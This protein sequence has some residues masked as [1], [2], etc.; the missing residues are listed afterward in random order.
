MLIENVTSGIRSEFGNITVVGTG[1]DGTPGTQAYDDGAQ[2]GIFIVTGGS[3]RST[4]AGTD[5]ADI[6]LRGFGGGGDGGANG[7]SIFQAGSSVTT[8]DGDISIFGVAA[9][10]DTGG[11]IGISVHSNAV[12]ATTGTGNILLDG[13]HSDPA[14][15]VGSDNNGVKIESGA[16]IGSSLSSAGAGSITI[17]GSAGDG[18]SGSHGVMVDGA[19]TRVTTVAGDISLTG[20]A[21]RGT[22]SNSAGVHVVNSGLVRTTGTGSIA[23]NGSVADGSGSLSGNEFQGVFLLNGATVES[24]STAAGSGTISIVGEGGDGV[25]NNHGIRIQ[26]STVNSNSGAIDLEGTG[27]K[28]SGTWNRGL[29][30]WQGA[31]VSA[32]NEASLSIDGTAGSGTDN[33]EGIQVNGSTVSVHDGDLLLNGQGSVTSTGQGNR[34]ILVTQ[35][36][37][38]T[39]SGTGNITINAAGGTGTTFNSG[40]RI[41]SNGTIVRVNDGDLTIVGTGNGSAAGDRNRG[42]VIGNDT[43]LTAVGSGSIFLTGTGG[44]GTFANFGITSFNTPEI[45]TISGDIVL[46]GIAGTSSNGIQLTSSAANPIVAGGA[47]NVTII[48]STTL[49]VTGTIDAATGNVLLQ[50][51]GELSL[52]NT[53]TATRIEVDSAGNSLAIGGTAAT[54]TGVNLTNTKLAN[55]NAVTLTVGRDATVVDTGDI[56]LNNVGELTFAPGASLDV[57]LPDTAAA[58]DPF[59]VVTDGKQVNLNNVG[60][61][62][63][64]N[65]TVVG[66]SRTIFE[67]A[68]AAGISV[69][70]MAGLPEGAQFI[71]GGLVF[72]VTYTGGIGGNDVV[73]TATGTAPVSTN[74]RIDVRNNDLFIEDLLL[75]GNDDSIS[76][77]AFDNAGIASYLI[78]ETTGVQLDLTS[79]AIAAGASYH[80]DGSGPILSQVVIPVSAFSGNINA[81]LGS[82]TDTV[83]IDF[84]GGAFAADI[85][86]NAGGQ[87]TGPGDSLILLGNSL[88]F[89]SETVTHT[90]QT[91]IGFDGNIELNDGTTISTITFT[92]LEPLTLA[93]AEEIVVN[94]PDG[95]DNNDVVIRSGLTANSVDILGSTFE[96]TFIPLVTG[97]LI[98]NGGN[99][100]DT[101]TVE[102][103]DLTVDLTV[104]GGIGVDSISLTDPV[105]SSGGDLTLIADTI[106]VATS[107]DATGGDGS[108][109]VTLTA[110]RNIVLNSGSSITVADGNAT[111]TA[112]ANGVQSGSFVGVDISAAIIESTGAGEINIE[113]RGGDEAGTDNHIGVLIRNGAAI[114]SSAASYQGQRINIVGEGGFGRSE[115]YGVRIEDPGTLIT[116]GYGSIT[117][118][119]TGRGTDWNNMGVLITENAVIAST[120]SG[121]GGPLD[122]PASINITGTGEGTNGGGAIGVK[123]GRNAGDGSLISTIDGDITIIGTAGEG[124]DNDAVNDQWQ[125][126]V[127]ILNG[128][129]VRSLGTGP[130]A[131]NITIIGTGGN[132]RAFSDGI[133]IQGV[134]SEVTA[135]DGNITLTGEA[136]RGV[137]NTAHGIH[138]TSNA[139]VEATGT[140][141]IT[142]TGTVK[143]DDPGTTADD[144]IHIGTTGMT[145]ELGSMVKSANGDVELTGSGR[146]YGVRL[147]GIDTRVESGSGAITI[148]ANPVTDL[149]HYFAAVSIESGVRVETTGI[150]GDPVAGGIILSGTV[151]RSVFSATAVDIN[152]GT[153]VTEFG[154]ILIS[155]GQTIDAANPN[156]L[157]LGVNIAG[158]VT[159]NGGGI[160]IEAGM[161]PGT[162]VGAGVEFN[163]AAISATSGDITVTAVA[164]SDSAI[165]L[166]GSTVLQTSNGGSVALN[167]VTA[168]TDSG[169]VGVGVFGGASIASNGTLEISG[170][171]DAVDGI[172]TI[173]TEVNSDGSDSGNAAFVTSNGLLMIS[174]SQDLV[175]R[176]G[177]ESGGGQ[178]QLTA[179]RHIRLQQAQN[180]I[181]TTGGDLTIRADNDGTGSGVYEQAT[182]ISTEGGDVTVIAADVVLTGIIDAAAGSITFQHSVDDSLI[183]LG[184]SGGFPAEAVVTDVDSYRFTV[185]DGLNW[186]F[187]GL[188]V[189]SAGD[190]NGDGIDDLLIAAPFRQVPDSNSGTFSNAGRVFVVFGGEANLR[191]L[192]TFDGTGFTG[193]EDRVISLEHLNPVGAEGSFP[194]GFEITGNTQ[195]GQ[196]GLSATAVGDMNGDGMDDLLIGAPGGF[197]SSGPSGDAF[198]VFGHQSG[199]INLSA[200]PANVLRL[201]G[202]NGGDRFGSRVA[203]GDVNG[204]GNSDLVIVNDRD[205]NRAYVVFGAAGDIA[206]SR[207]ALDSIDG[208]AD[209]VLDIGSLDETTGMIIS[210]SNNI[211]SVAVGDI[212]GDGTDDLILGSFGYDSSSPVGFTYVLFGED[213]ADLDAALGPADGQIDAND[214]YSLR[215]QGPSNENASPEV[216]VIGDLNGDGFRDL[217]IGA[218]Y[219]AGV[220][221]TGFNSRV[222]VVFGGAANLRALDTFGEAVGAT[223]D[224]KIQLSNLNGSNGFF[225]GDIDAFGA[226]GGKL[227][228]NSAGDING[229]GFDDLLIGAPT[230]GENY[231]TRTGAVHVVFGQDTDTDNDGAVDQPFA[232]A[233]SANSLGSRG[234][235]LTGPDPFER[236]GYAVT[237]AGDINGD[238]I[239]DLAA[240]APFNSYFGY[241]PESPGSVYVVFG[242]SGTPG[243]VAG[244]FHLSDTELA[245]LGATNVIIDAPGADSITRVIDD[246]YLPS[247]SGLIFNGGGIVEICGDITVDGI[248]PLGGSTGSGSGTTFNQD[249]VL[250]ENVTLSDL[251]SGVFFN[252]SVTFGTYDPDDPVTAEIETIR[253]L[254]LDVT[255][256][257]QPDPVIVIGDDAS[258]ILTLR[259]AGTDAD[260]LHEQIIVAGKLELATSLQLAVDTSFSTSVGMEI[261]LIE[262]DG[263]EAVTGAFA[264]VNGGS[265]AEG[266]T[267]ILNGENYVLSY[268][269]GDGNDV[270]L[271][272]AIGNTAPIAD[273]GGPYVVNEGS[274]VTLNASG[275]SDA[276]DADSNLTFEWD[277]DG[278]GQFDDAIGITTTFTALDG[279]AIQSV[280][281]RVTD[282]GGL[283]STTSAD[284]T[285]NNVAPTV[286]A[287]NAFVTAEEGT[288]ATN[289]G[290]FDDVGDDV[291]TITA[292]IGSVTQG[293]GTWNWSYDT[294]DGPDNSGPVT[295][296][297]TDSDG[298]TATVAFD[299]T[300]TNVTPLFD[301]GVNETVA[302]TAAGAF[303]RTVSF[304]D[305]G[306]LDAHTISIDYDGDGTTDET[307]NPA[308][309]A[310]SFNLSHTFAASGVYTV[311]ITVAD[312]DGASLTD[313]FVVTVNAPTIEFTAATYAI[314]EAAGNSMQVTLTRTGDS[315]TESVVRVSL[316]GGTATATGSAADFDAASFPLDVV[317]AAGESSKTV[318]LPI[319]DDDVGELSETILLSVI[320]VSNASIGAVNS[321]EVTIL[322]NDTATFTINDVTVT[323][324]GSTTFTISLDQQIDRAVDVTVNLSGDRTDATIASPTVTFAAGE[325]SKTVTIAAT[326]DNIVEASETLT[327]SLTV[328]RAEGYSTDV[329][330]TAEVTVIDND[331]ATFTINDVTVTE[332]GSTVL[333]ILLDH[334]IDTAVDVTVNLSGDGS[335]ASI[336]SPTVTF[337]AG[338]TSKT[339]IIAA[340]DDNIVEASETLTASLTVFG[341]EGYS[342]DVSDTAEVTI[343]DN[344]TAT[345]TI[346]DVTVTE[347]G[348]RTFTIS[349]DQ[350]I[351]RAVD[352]AVNL[353]GNGTDATIASPTVT[354]AAGETSKTVTIT[355]TDD[356][357]VEASE[358]L[359][360]SL[361]VF[362][363]EGYSVDATDTGAVTIV[364]NDTATFTIDD[365]IVSEDVGTATFIISLNN[366]LDV[367][368]TIELVLPA[369]GDYSIVNSSVVF[370]AGSATPQAV[371]V[372][373]T[374][375]DL[376]EATEHFT[377]SLS[378]FGAE[379]YSVDVTDT[380]TLTIIDNDAGSGTATLTID[381]VTALEGDQ[382][383]TEFTFTV[384]L[385][386]VVDTTVTV[387]VETGFFTSTDITEVA[388]AE[389]FTARSETL[390]FAP[391]DTA[392]TFTVQV[393]GD[394]RI[395]QN[396]RFV[397]NLSNVQSG[398]RDVQIGDGQGIGTI[399]MDD[400]AVV[401]I[402]ALT[403]AIVEGDVALFGIELLNED[404]SGPAEFGVG[405]SAHFDVDASTNSLGSTADVSDIDIAIQA[406]VESRSD[407]TIGSIIYTAPT[408]G[409]VMSPAVLSL[410]TLDDLLIER[411]ETLTVSV[412]GLTTADGIPTTGSTTAGSVDVAIADNDGPAVWMLTQMNGAD[413]ST[414]EGD[415]AVFELSL[416]GTFGSDETATVELDISPESLKEL[417]I[418]PGQ[419]VA[420]VDAVRAAA[421]IDPDVT[422]TGTGP[423]TIHFAAEADG[424]S[425]RTLSIRLP[426]AVD[427]YIEGPEVLETTLQNP[428]GSTFLAPVIFGGEG[429]VYTSQTVLLDSDGPGEWSILGTTTVDEG[430]L[431][432]FEI[433]LAG[434]FGSG[435]TATVR[436]TQADIDT[437][438]ND[439]GDT[440]S[441]IVDLFD[442]LAAAV[443]GRGDLNFDSVTG[444][445]TFVSQSDG[446]A[447][448]PIRVALP[449]QNDTAVEGGERFQVGLGEAGSG[450][451]SALQVNNVA[452]LVSTFINDTQGI[453]GPA[454]G[455]PGTGVTA[456]YFSGGRNQVPGSDSAPDDV[457]PTFINTSFGLLPLPPSNSNTETT[458]TDHSPDDNSFQELEEDLL[459]I[460]DLLEGTNLEEEELFFQIVRPD[461]TLGPKIPLSLEMLDNDEV[462]ATF[463]KFPNNVYRIQYR[464]AGLESNQTLF[465]L[466]VRD[467]H[468]VP[469]LIPSEDTAV[470]APDVE[471]DPIVNDPPTTDPT[472]SS[473]NHGN[474]FHPRTAAIQRAAQLLTQPPTTEDADTSLTRTGI[475][476]RRHAK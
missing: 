407:L 365:V 99:Q 89:V 176:A 214:L 267:V 400:T 85:N 144:A 137:T 93:S 258:D 264:S 414:A 430:G 432:E 421:E 389:D 333:T 159:S 300:V 256:S 119:G 29:L 431:A 209:G 287:T 458:A 139:L 268:L 448:A 378:V 467:H 253:R 17:T 294:T 263:T 84:S 229:D 106:D 272:R 32:A 318:T 160:T 446:D 281:L 41:Q 11:S 438:G 390:T 197:D 465:E 218:P 313:S 440:T 52:G 398:G 42:I 269:G 323:E 177:V 306:L 204:D 475:L 308:I 198:L 397:V 24:T 167:G 91:G 370:T 220:D 239:D 28:G 395:E 437:D 37:L 22:G 429:S 424:D 115:N 319:F 1:G 350:Q 67:Q 97:S 127:E 314:G 3:I 363:A 109:S 69:G 19:G 161:A 8:I 201:S 7:L 104:D 68:G 171:S 148:T 221:G 274:E 387:D 125:I 463:K 80:D 453:G 417:G 449:I 285:V 409:A 130:N 60:L 121:S 219:A 327:A 195:D 74:T 412:T 217:A 39:A 316:T 434:D 271:E 83:T 18:V 379:G 361:T 35:S 406:L 405:V 16:V 128:P 344:D 46:T 246:V 296:T 53:V 92:G 455:D 452:S 441:N 48:S 291:V 132:G 59:V 351:D 375:D 364:D 82:G 227:D 280:G 416:Q 261:V 110:D 399:L 433:R 472:V 223:G 136:G 321:T 61:D 454:D 30:I 371:V 325:T 242:Q 470:A 292:S 194:G 366:V 315:L 383:M 337:A 444:T 372:N 373:I 12:I 63:D 476:I 338:E 341:A 133:Q 54:V 165:V 51:A 326:E 410:S 232:A 442:Q 57:N 78:T 320:D 152:G 391:G 459:Q 275:S 328:F 62:L 215:L 238:G 413:E 162:Y 377:A 207:T 342:T 236:L 462:I 250:C 58:D 317:F 140:G 332:G 155:G 282:S 77:T 49:N 385:N 345:F 190:I 245:L 307:L 393:S 457:A 411:T 114:R 101:I 436:V 367:D 216:A 270:T 382:G 88:P 301:A 23:I 451:G 260:T 72:S 243:L 226:E 134:G 55:L 200:P 335:E 111:L 295:I 186:D 386:G 305:P 5:A 353:S 135:V 329:S 150:A 357:I 118:D 87:P 427:G 222:Y 293:V 153:V 192:D 401:R 129:D 418:A 396:E 249:V 34:G 233:L 339:V 210:T 172:A 369:S 90:D 146:G 175:I 284:I 278:D 96:D 20:V 141:N 6:V 368:T 435:E 252:G 31:I 75:A 184:G 251:G 158:D 211:R 460:A 9:P 466:N 174:S 461:G 45:T 343:I 113:G 26:S 70:S 107:I 13:R 376:I 38:I 225:V 182:D 47:G 50:T 352:V 202:P 173:I 392:R 44:S 349:L 474:P 286:V 149:D 464:D 447:M 164:E 394:Q 40:I 310:R 163:S 166:S 355:A 95:I 156:P 205:P 289:S 380:G 86:V 331:T 181:K 290:V 336:V 79:A 14:G 419:S 322:D 244:Q 443:A 145:V 112:N 151:G 468:I 116:A 402:Q 257:T 142:A 224:S 199:D 15:V 303:S 340:T 193:P 81:N 273:A 277:L 445:L 266:A 206:T 259:L 456:G 66:Q 203:A 231:S 98:I 299:L 43:R 348:S 157:G 213:L 71:A 347:G 254:T 276:Q 187:T 10:V 196:L 354:F 248:V 21:G 288:T 297:A 2:V 374:D 94:L 312:N 103:L 358:T 362:G 126:G 168:G 425:M 255:S 471:N 179:G 102:G 283:F 241:R 73:L 170:T 143:A 123:I 124:N 247:S 208:S 64:V 228:I 404:E 105:F 426:I 185:P 309:G 36:S 388:G 381:D 359:T 360:A 428:A 147:T 154:E 415:D 117:I 346:N 330:D 178:M 188:E 108:G 237:G 334:E 302:A 100:A 76:V 27:G 235:T 33:N 439:V 420:F 131:G 265:A 180:P 423:L 469:T 25:N 403:T 279:P 189:T 422:V 240:G 230:T 191:A 324:G 183:Q 298:A 356:N 169:D 311:S 65:N 408:E 234:F 473:I 120:G 450:T 304:I 262:N 138:I 56:E 384:T 122:G 4:G 212:T